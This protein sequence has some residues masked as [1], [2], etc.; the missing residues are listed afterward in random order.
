MVNHILNIFHLS[1]DVQFL[2][3]TVYHLYLVL[4]GHQWHYSFFID[5]NL[6]DLLLNY[7]Y[8][9]HVVDASLDRLLLN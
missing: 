1:L 2:H 9:D 3:I 6:F 7:G 8:S 4:Y 5:R